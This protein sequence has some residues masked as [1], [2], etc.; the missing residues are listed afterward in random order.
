MVMDLSFEAQATNS[1]ERCKF[2][3]R[4]FLKGDYNREP[5][6]N[7]D[8]EFLPKFDR[9]LNVYWQGSGKTFTTGDALLD[10]AFECFADLLRKKLLG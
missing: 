2:T 5:E 10:F 8:F 3:V 7:G 9:E 6:V 4:L 1:V